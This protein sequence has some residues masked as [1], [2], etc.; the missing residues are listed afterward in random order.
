MIDDLRREVRFVDIS[1]II[2]HH[3]LNVLSQE[4]RSVSSH[5]TV[6][7]TKKHDN[8]TQKSQYYIQTPQKNTRTNTNY[9]KEYNNHNHHNMD[10]KREHTKYGEV[11]GFI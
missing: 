8:P 1:G 2:D 11:T 6:E 4:S 9:A 3:C 5:S 7:H 10:R